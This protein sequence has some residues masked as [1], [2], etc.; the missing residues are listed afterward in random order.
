MNSIMLDVAGANLRQVATHELGHVLGLG[1][2]GNIFAVMYPAYYYRDNFALHHDDI[3]R[4]QAIYG[5]K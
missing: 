3:Q 1:H 5:T 4:I 2:S